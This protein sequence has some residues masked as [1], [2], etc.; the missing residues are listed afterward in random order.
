MGVWGVCVGVWVLGC[1]G[2]VLTLVYFKNRWS[3]REGVICDIERITH[4]AILQY[5]YRTNGAQEQDK[6]N[7]NH[8]NYICL[9]SQ[10]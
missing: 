2:G 8:D 1:V 4:I 6:R 7:H 9:V 3:P 5:M 10:N